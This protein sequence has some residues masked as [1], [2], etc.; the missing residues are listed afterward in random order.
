MFYGKRRV[1]LTKQAVCCGELTYYVVLPIL[2][3]GEW[4][5]MRDLYCDGRSYPP[6]L[7]DRTGCTDKKRK[8]IFPHL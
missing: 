5:G 8:Y 7:T 6:A 2:V 4:A 3:R 1:H